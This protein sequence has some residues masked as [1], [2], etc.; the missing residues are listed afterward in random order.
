MDSFIIVVANPPAPDF[1][2][3]DKLISTAYSRNIP[4]SIVVNKVDIDSETA[5]DIVKNYSNAVDN[6]FCISAKTG[7]G[8]ERFKEFLKGRLIVFSGQ[9]AVGKTSIV[10]RL[11]GE[12]RRT[13]EVSYKTQKGKQTTTVS[14]ITESNGIRIIDTPGFTAMEVDIEEDVFPWSYPEFSEIAVNCRFRGC[15]HINEPDC[16]IKN[17][18]DEGLIYRERY[19]R[20]KQIYKELKEKRKYDKK[21]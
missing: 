20:Y 9:S 8:V 11:F 12:N 15:R 5:N 18:V 4:C 16:A 6:I 21:Y 7:E 2:L 17:A 19:V 13:G 3:F 14:E 10:N 1:C